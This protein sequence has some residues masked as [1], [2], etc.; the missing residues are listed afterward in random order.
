MTA[1]E[2]IDKCTD[3]LHG[4]GDVDKDYQQ[5]MIPFIEALDAGNVK[6]PNE[7]CFYVSIRLRRDEK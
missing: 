7:Y 1:E 4:L 5:A 3:Y 6:A 2:L